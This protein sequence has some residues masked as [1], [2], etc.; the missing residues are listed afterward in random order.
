M[1]APIP[2]KAVCL[3]FETSGST[4]GGDSSILHQGISFGLV[5]FDTRTFE[6][7][8]M[9]YQEIKFDASK[10]KWSEEAQAIHGLSREHLEENGVSQEDAAFAMC[11]MLLKH[12]GP[13]P[14]IMLLGH[15]L[16]FDICFTKQLL[17]QFG[18]MFKIHHVHLDTAGIA[19]V[20][21]GIH[22]SDLVFD[23]LGCGER[24]LHNALEDCLMTIEACRRIRMVFQAGLSE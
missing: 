17:E 1:A 16:S 19:L 15:N 18:L 24:E 8:D 7:I 10:Y 12:F 2:T 14:T 13:S 20:T 9:M 5:V 3:D 22:K 11:E 23:F 4:W 21:L 6:P